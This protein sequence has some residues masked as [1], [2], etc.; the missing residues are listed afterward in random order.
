MKKFDYGELE[1][2]K[3]NADTEAI[4][5]VSTYEALQLI[6]N[7]DRVAWQAVDEALDDITELVDRVAEKLCSG[8][9][10]FYVGAGTSGR[11][12]VI[13]AAECPPTFGV[14]REKVQGIIAGGSEAMLYSIEGAEDNEGDGMTAIESRGIGEGDA[15]VGIA[16]SGITPFV[17]GGLRQASARAGFTA[18]LTCNRN[19]E[20][21][22]VDKVVVLDTGPEPIAGS[23]RMK[24]GLATRMV[25]NMISTVSMIR[26]GKVYKNV[27]IDVQPWCAK[28]RD[29][30]ER[31]VMEFGRVN[32]ESAA[33]LLTDAGDS[34]PIALVMARKGVGKEE[35]KDI[36][37]RNGGQVFRVI[38]SWNEGGAA[39]V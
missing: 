1:T 4:D 27:M 32:K 10:L 36:L 7:E 37:R 24:A 31:I 6:H 23:T 34:V 25:L 35:A 30:A 18:F 12:G 21:P 13:D 8:G 11:L 3:R 14:S 26:M 22:K 29:R 38:D 16:A 17:R 9:R 5:R 2:E 19:I 20:F 15:V 39:G 28:L 33:T